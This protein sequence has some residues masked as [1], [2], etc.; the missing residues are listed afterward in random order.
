MAGERHAQGIMT[1]VVPIAAAGQLAAGDVADTIDTKG[2]P[3]RGVVAAMKPGNNVAIV[4][5]GAGVHVRPG[6]GS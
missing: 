4:I 3:V 2:D 6:G 1:F 5:I